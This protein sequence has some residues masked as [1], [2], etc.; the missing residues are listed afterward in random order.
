[1][2]ACIFKYSF[3]TNE[4]C[5]SISYIMIDIFGRDEMKFGYGIWDEEDTNISIANCIANTHVS[6][7]HGQVQSHLCVSP[8]VSQYL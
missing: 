4:E 3:S 8:R 6:D 1:M 5:V 7:S 2:F